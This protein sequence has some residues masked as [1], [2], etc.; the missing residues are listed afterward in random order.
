MKTFTVTA[1]G[2]NDALACQDL[3]YK[4]SASFKL[5]ISWPAFFPAYSTKLVP[6]FGAKQL[7]SEICKGDSGAAWYVT[8]DGQQLAFALQSDWLGGSHDA[9]GCPCADPGDAIRGPSLPKWLDWIEDKSAAEGAPLIE[10]SGS[11]GGYSYVRFLNIGSIQQP[12]TPL[13]RPIALPQLPA[14]P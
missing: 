11:A 9:E 8:R 7:G 6:Y 2:F 14:L 5:V 13:V 3:G 10:E 1:F 4:R 12:S